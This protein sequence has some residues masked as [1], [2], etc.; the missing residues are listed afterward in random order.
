MSRNNQQTSS[1]N[2]QPKRAPAVASGYATTA[3]FYDQVYANAAP[4]DLE[5]YLELARDCDGGVLELGCGTGR[6]ALPLARAGHRVT[7]VDC[8][9]EMLDVFRAKLESEPA[10]VRERVAL[11]EGTMEGIDLGETFGLVTMPFRAL[12][13]MLTAAQ[14]RAALGTVARHLAPGGLY[15]FNAFNPSLGYIVDA[16]RRGRV[17]QQDQ[18]WTDEASGNQYRR[19]HSVHYDPGDQLITVD[20]RYEEFDAQGR[21]LSTWCE[22]MQLRWIYRWEAEHLL[23]LTGYEISA[24]YGDYEKSP[25]DSAAKELIY[26]CKRAD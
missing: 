9:L 21:L 4:A 22:P 2:R 25:L 6:V 19:Q 26:V 10:A 16:M 15:V 8:S 17:W 14:Q 24:A 3:R 18:Q 5:Y 23:R 7:G 13:H 1:A 11:V 20:W 12:Q